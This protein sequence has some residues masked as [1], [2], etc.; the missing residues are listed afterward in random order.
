MGVFRRLDILSLLV[1]VGGGECVNFT[2]E[3]RVSQ[4]EFKYV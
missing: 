1:V 4:H 3:R 2:V